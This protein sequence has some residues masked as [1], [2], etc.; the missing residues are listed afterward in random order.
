MAQK[1][2][3]MVTS[4]A[5]AV[6]KG[7]TGTEEEFAEGVLAS[8]EYAD[9]AQASATAAAQSKI[10]AEAAA[11]SVQASATQIATNTADIADI[12]SDLS[13]VKENITDISVNKINWW[14][15]GAINSN[16]TNSVSNTRLRSDFNVTTGANSSTLPF[17][18]LDESVMTRSLES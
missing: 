8:A 5:Y 11:S 14:M 15:R 6:S 1:D 7:Y 4:Y 18:V 13:E 2:L 16:G 3:G 17:T 12:K 10:D 9:N